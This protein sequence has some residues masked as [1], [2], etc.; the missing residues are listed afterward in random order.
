MTILTG[1][2]DNIK[3]FYSKGVL[4][5]TIDNKLCRIDLKGSDSLE[6]V[7]RLTRLDNESFALMAGLQ[8]NG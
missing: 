1:D 7:E 4:S 2:K 6:Q 3:T 5:R 8:R